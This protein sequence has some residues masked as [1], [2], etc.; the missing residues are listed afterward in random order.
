[1]KTKVKKF[2]AAEYLTTPERRA[3]YLAA[4][5]ETGDVDFTRDALGVLVR[6]IGVNKVAAGAG[7]HRV[8]LSKALGA[9]GNPEFSTVL[10][11]ITAL[12]LKVS[13]L[14]AAERSGKKRGPVVTAAT[15]RKI[16]AKAAERTH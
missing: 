7:I 8:S 10:K 16:A 14:P 6:A 3:A 11:I 9:H 15:I 2:D 4:A 13:A 1:V 12:R 5:L